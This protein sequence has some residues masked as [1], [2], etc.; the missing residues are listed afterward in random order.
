[1][2]TKRKLL[3][4]LALVGLAGAFG[5]C[6]QPRLPLIGVLVH[7]VEAADRR[8]LD[9]LRDGLRELGYV[10]GK[11]CRIEVRYSDNRIERLPALARELLALKPDVVVA[12]PV[13]TA[14]ALHRETKTVPIVMASGA[15]AQNL[16][17]I[18]SLARPGGNVTGLTNQG[19]ELTVK[20]FELLRE[21][22]PRAKRVVTLSS[23]LGSVEA[24][25]RTD[26]RS[27]AKRY[28]MEL[29][30]A[31]ADAPEKLSALSARCQRE[32]C[33]ALVVLLD[34]NVFNFRREIVAFAAKLRIPAI[35]P[36]VEFAEEGGLV[37][38]SVNARQLWQRA[39]TYVDKILKGAR[40]GDLPVEQ[41][42]RFE[43]VVNIKTAK[44]LGITV[45][46]TVLLRADRVIE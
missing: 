35:Y 33:E 38:Y 27:G 43:L 11:T 16:G 13:R 22:A 46:Q 15:G 2:I 10:D 5:A 31:L 18:A 7:A 42:A 20:H 25:V 14:Q 9:A 28:G 24:E 23:G 37:A 17:L 1:M 45:P 19:D 41:P 36:G 30:E 29:I 4:V 32:R 39:A 44:A 26:S 34:P 6:A 8:R 12:S 3:V 40:P 21:V